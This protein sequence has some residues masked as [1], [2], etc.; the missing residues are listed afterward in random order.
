MLLCNNHDDRATAQN[1]ERIFRSIHDLLSSVYSEP[2]YYYLLRAT[3]HTVHKGSAL[4]Q[5]SLI[6]TVFRCVLPCIVSNQALVSPLS[7]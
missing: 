2:V 6:H 4:L 1:K 7:D 5:F 3:V